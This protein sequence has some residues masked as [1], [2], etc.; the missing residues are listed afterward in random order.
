MS[1]RTAPVFGERQNTFLSPHRHGYGYGYLVRPD[2]RGSTAK[3]AEARRE[4]DAS[5]RLFEALDE[6]RFD[7]VRRAVSD[8]RAC[9]QTTQRYRASNS[10]PLSP[11]RYALA[12][13]EAWQALSAHCVRT[14]IVLAPLGGR[15]FRERISAMNAIIAW[16]LQQP[17]VEIP[18]GKPLHLALACGLDLAAAVM[19]RRAPWLAC[20]K[21]SRGKTVVHVVCGLP[22]GIKAEDA[23]RIICNL[24]HYGADCVAPDI[25][26]ATPL[27]DLIRV[28][29]K[30]V[31]S[32]GL[33]RRRRY[34]NGLEHVRPIINALLA[35][36]ARLDVYD[37]SG[38]CPVDLALHVGL[39]YVDLIQRAASLR[40]R[41]VR[42]GHTFEEYDDNKSFTKGDD[43][44][45]NKESILRRSRSTGAW[46][47]LPDDVVLKIMSYL[48]PCDIVKGIA[49]TCQSLRRIAAND[50]LWNH[51]EVTHCLDVVRESVV[52]ISH[53][54]TASV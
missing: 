51:L 46:G 3:S 4:K 20:T 30:P 9:L 10:R 17:E 24:A 40:E 53:R 18:E 14:G 54:C 41:L 43:W 23:A 19:C 22:D 33:I 27:H 47:I 1:R 32:H 28:S 2:E 21:D 37:N 52:R 50:V 48:T 45:C 13:C 49:G 42:N 12:N 8:D 6:P 34:A 31:S 7:E 36:G 39:D 38:R 11:I 15:T 29:A 35:H 5:T 44:M 26:G 16:L 25:E